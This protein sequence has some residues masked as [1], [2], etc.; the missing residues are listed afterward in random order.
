MRVFLSSV[1]LL[2]SIALVDAQEP[3][4]WTNRA[5][6]AVRGDNLQKTGGCDGC[7][8]AGAVSAQ[9]IRSGDG[10]VEFGVGEDWKY[11]LAGLSR[12]G[13]NRPASSEN[14]D[15][16]IRINGNGWADIVENGRYIGGDTD[17]GPGDL[18]RVA[19]ENGQVRY[20]K[21][22]EVFHVSQKR[23]AYPLVFAAALGSVGATI[24]D[25]RMAASGTPDRSNIGSDEQFGTL[26]RNSDGRISRREWAGTRGSFDQ[27]DVNRDGV[28][29][30]RELGVDE[31][32]R[33]GRDIV[34][35]AGELVVVAAT[36]R[37]T[38]TGLAVRAGDRLSFDAEG[39][40]EM[41]GPDDRAT[42]AGS[43]RLAPQAPVRDSSAGTLIGRIGESAPF[44]VG[45]RRTI[46]GVPI[47]GRLYLGVNDDYLEDN[48]GEYRVQV[49][50][51]PR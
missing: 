36:E 40:I 18:F 12:A 43:Q 9:A 41:S 16:A 8:D 1:V 51:N 3:V 31:P 19:V 47:S 34:G 22:G 10:Y 5:N 13:R 50:I 15:F 6:V 49:T 24:A 37:W 27:R 38:D 4:N 30:R 35:T 45:S 29:T 2:A 44:V 20:S 42:P 28:I 33:M 46:A 21:N 23:P 17:Y 39:S 7:V 32:R 11:W 48:R 25:A 14:I 26:D